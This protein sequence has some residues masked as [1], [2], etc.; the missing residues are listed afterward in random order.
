VRGWKDVTPTFLPDFTPAE[1]GYKTYSSDTLYLV[2]P[3]NMDSTHARF[4]FSKLQEEFE[5]KFSKANNFYDISQKVFFLLLL[6]RIVSAVDAGITAKAYN[7]EMLGK[8][9]M[10]QR[11]NIEQKQVNSGWETYSGYALVFR[12]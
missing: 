6:D 7:D 10:W 2:Y 3:A 12:F 4:G 8:Q 9:S 1:P 5:I 11:I